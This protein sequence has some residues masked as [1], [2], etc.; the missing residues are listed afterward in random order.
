[1]PRRIPINSG[2]Y[3]T[4]KKLFIT[5]LRNDINKANLQEYFSRFGNV[6]DV[7]LIKDGHGTLRKNE[8]T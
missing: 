1:M 8:I 5:A 4:V 3:L 7:Y 2:A 6:T